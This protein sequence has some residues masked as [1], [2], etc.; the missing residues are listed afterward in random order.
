MKKAESLETRFQSPGAAYRGKPF[1]AWNG[2]LNEDELRRQ[3]RVMHRMGLGGFFMHSR[4]GLATPYLGKEWFD[5]TRACIDE[6]KQLGMEAWIY[7]EDRWPSGAAGGIVTRDPRYRQKR[8][9]LEAGGKAA[10]DKD[11]LA[12]FEAVLDGDRATEVRR[13][14][15]GQRGAKGKTLLVFRRVLAGNSD[16]YNGFT[17]LDTMS[18]DAVQAF[19]K[20]THEAY[21]REIGDEFGKAVPGIFTDEPNH[22]A[23]LRDWSIDQLGAGGTEIPWTDALP[24][25]FRERYGYDL[26]ARLPE[27]FFDVDGR[28]T[29]PARQDYHDCKTHLFVDAFARQIGE[30]CD[31][32]RMIHTGHVLEEPTTRSQTNMVGSSMRF[33]EHMQA[34]GIDILCDQSQE[35]D[36]AKQCASVLNQTGRRWM[37]SELYG[38]TGWDFGFDGHKA[39]GDWQA[40]LG[41]NL[42]CQ[43]LS[44]YTMEGEAKRDYPASIFHHSP[45]WEEYR[46]VEDY[47][48]RVGVL[49]S[50]GAPVRELLVIHPVESGWARCRVGWY[51]AQDSRDIELR[52]AMVRNWLLDA[53]IDFDWGDEEMLSRLARIRRGPGGPRFVV[54]KASYA[55]VLAPPMVTIRSSTLLL[56]QRF[57]EAGGTVIFAGDPAGY[58]DGEANDA[59]E[60][61]AR[62]AV[63]APLQEADVVAAAGAGRVI[64][65]KS[66]A[67][68]EYGPA[69]YQLR[70]KDGEHYLF[71]QNR[72]RER[73]SGELTLELPFAGSVEEWEPETGAMYAAEARKTRNGVTVRTS[74]GPC[75]HRLFVIGKRRRALSKR[76]VY[77]ALKQRTLGSDAWEYQLTEPNVLVLDR[78]EYRTGGKGR[79]QAAREILK[80]DRAVREANGFYVRGGGMRQPWAREASRKPRI[81]LEL[82]YTFTVTDLPS[83]GL[84]LA[85]EKPRRFAIAVNGNTVDATAACGWWVDTSIETVP[86]DP[87]FLRRG[88]NSIV[89]ATDYGEDDDLEAHFLLGSFG[90]TVKGTEC[91][92]GRLPAALRPGD[93][94]KQG[95]PF[96]SG[97]VTYRKRVKGLKRKGARL[98]VELPEWSGACVRF[99]VDGR[100]VTTVG[101]PPYE[102]DLTE[103]MEADEHEIGIQ[104]FGSRRNAFGPLHL[105][106]P[107]GLWVGPQ[108]FVSEG[109]RWQEAYELVACGLLKAP[110]LA[111][112]S[113]TKGSR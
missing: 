4:V 108:E 71:L 22:G 70:R 55:A 37:L 69:L 7:D 62:Q 48:A 59:A 21:R 13:L 56:L 68:G 113:A 10:W 3:I 27:I 112:R 100:P 31:Q 66:A 74:L 58:V 103:A 23:T 39:V 88:E 105:A 46:T 99:L 34:P 78:A 28:L 15:K 89:L 90:V 11:V 26:I 18:H 86:V 54:G 79:W 38:C 30:W 63:C 76:P 9:R 29:S 84:W 35:L 19:V 44:W 110:V 49:M 36:T 107:R 16:W 67:G 95:L 14:R 60:V 53:N 25:V 104:V 102:A 65:L 6:A 17:Y 80:L 73:D 12:V 81:P 33:Y 40:A 109:K 47:F 51:S 64:S 50:E 77:Q 96:Y 1:W 97:A 57:I 98:F 43:H 82:K 42:R 75:G 101:W 91:T 45:W 85:V 41:V 94:G 87:S 5:L 32:N 8:L 106:Q 2:L 92:L 20:V 93:W 72:D 24:K 83:G 111:W 52:T 61:V